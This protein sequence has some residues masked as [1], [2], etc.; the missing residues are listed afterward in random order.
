MSAALVFL[1]GFSFRQNAWVEGS[2]LSAGRAVSRKGQPT[3]ERNGLVR[4]WRARS[5]RPV[6]SRGAR[7]PDPLAASLRG[8]RSSVGRGRRGV[9]AV[10]YR[11][12]VAVVVEAKIIKPRICEGRPGEEAKLLPSQEATA[13]KKPP[14]AATEPTTAKAKSGPVMKPAKAAA[15]ETA[16]AMKPAGAM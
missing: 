4:R 5:A 11:R 16:G 14:V 15:A 1:H 12:A 3:S 13:T 6:V 10:A 7:V 8:R 9:V 2:C